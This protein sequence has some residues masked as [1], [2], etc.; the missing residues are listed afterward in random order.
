MAVALDDGGF[1]G[2]YGCGGGASKSD[3]DDSCGDGRG[4]KTTIN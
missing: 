3:S 1:S 4:E 2:G